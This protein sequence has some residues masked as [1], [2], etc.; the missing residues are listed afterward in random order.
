MPFIAALNDTGDLQ[1]LV[2][3]ETD[4]ADMFYNII[5][6]NPF[7][8]EFLIAGKDRISNE[9]VLLRI[10]IPTDPEEW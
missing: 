4:L 8:C 3:L 7:E 5:E 10:I 2:I 9:L 6:T 1:K